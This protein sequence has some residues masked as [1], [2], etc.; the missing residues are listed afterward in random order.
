MN[1]LTFIGLFLVGWSVP[2]GEIQIMTIGFVALLVDYEI[3]KIN[4][5]IENCGPWY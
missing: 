3:R 1:R 5:K 4:K 2:Y